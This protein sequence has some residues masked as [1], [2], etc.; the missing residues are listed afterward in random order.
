MCKDEG[1]VN[2]EKD[3]S[4]MIDL[5]FSSRN[6]YIPKFEKATKWIIPIM[7]IFLQAITIFYALGYDIDIRKSAVIIVSL[8]FLVIG[9]YLPK[10]DYVKNYNLDTEKAKKINRFIG[11]E[12][13]VMG[14]LSLTSTLLPPI[15]TVIWLFLLIPYATISVIYGFKVVRKK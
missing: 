13:V 6:S 3:S 15:A 7:S 1:R 10:F 9:N 11:F 12:T 4:R 14:I 5:R 2:Q 8:V